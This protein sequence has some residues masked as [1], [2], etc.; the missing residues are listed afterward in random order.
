MIK[1][2]IKYEFKLSVQPSEYILNA[3]CGD[4]LSE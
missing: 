4:F 2:M 3:E 1:Y